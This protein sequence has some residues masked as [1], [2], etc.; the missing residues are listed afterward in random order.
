MQPMDEEHKSRYA[1]GKKG[2]AN[3]WKTNSVIQSANNTVDN[4]VSNTRNNNKNRIDKNRTDKKKL[5]IE[6]KESTDKPDVYKRQP[7]W[8]A[9]S[10]RASSPSNNSRFAMRS[11]SYAVFTNLRNF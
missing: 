7:A 1:G 8:S 4:A 5:S 3:R 6:S 9:P 11:C 10:A 2:M